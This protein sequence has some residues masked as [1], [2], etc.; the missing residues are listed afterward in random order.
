MNHFPSLQFQQT[1]SLA[2]RNGIKCCT[3]GRSD[4]GKTMLCATAPTPVIAAAE[5]GLLSLTDHNAARVFGDAPYTPPSRIPAVEIR[6]R[7]A[8]YDF[9][10]WCSTPE[11]RQYETVCL[12]S[13]SAIADYILADERAK[14]KGDAYGKAYG[15]LA[16]DFLA[17]IRH[18]TTTLG[19]NVYAIAKQDRNKDDFSGAMLYGP[20]FPGQQIGK[21]L[22]YEFDELFCLRLMPGED[23]QTARWLQTAADFQYE[24]KDR[25][26][27]LAPFEYP[28]L[29]HV[30][31]KIRETA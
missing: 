12:D 16:D 26:G 31:N 22:P 8:L 18:L 20:M 6:T 23:G 27:A 14:T 5:R 17:L 24:A 30:F 11:G 1:S 13:L 21:N 19:H 4:A 7:D 25:S 3:Y 9:A 2:I 28:H 10:R 15:A 29:G